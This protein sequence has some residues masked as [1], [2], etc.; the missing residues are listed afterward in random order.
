MIPSLSHSIKKSKISKSIKIHHLNQNPTPVLYFFG[1]L[2]T[3]HPRQRTNYFFSFSFNPDPTVRH[4]FWSLVVGGTILYTAHNSLNQNMMQRF[5]SLKNVNAARKANIIYTVGMIVIILL[6]CFN[7]LLLF[8]NYYNCDPLIT[9]R[10]ENRDQLLPLMVLETFN[11]LPGLTGLFI[12][13]IFSAALSSVSTGLNSMSAVVLEDFIKPYTKKKTSMRTNTIILRATVLFLGLTSVGLVYVVEML[14]NTSTVLQLTLSL[15]TACFGLLFGVYIIGFFLPWVNKRATFYGGIIGSTLMMLYVFKVQV[16]MAYGHIIFPRKPFSIDGCSNETNFD[17]PKT[18]QLTT[19]TSIYQISYLYYT[20]IGTL[21][22]LLFSFIL[23]CFFGLE[24][25][26]KIDGKLLAPLVRKYGK[27]IQN[28]D[29]NLP[30][31]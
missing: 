16:E 4:T 11:D 25:A 1:Q 7:G 14:G 15:P 26:K 18:Q 24:D 28:E 2:I 3:Q 5:L 22:V 31:I 10:I 29:L 6:C 20:F 9:K 27:P 12:S 23:T 19:E 21:M 17:P 13:G 30:A 8:A